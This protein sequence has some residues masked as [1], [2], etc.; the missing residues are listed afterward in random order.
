VGFGFN[1]LCHVPIVDRKCEV[2]SKSLLKNSTNLP[3]EELKK[4]FLSGVHAAKMTGWRDVVVV[5]S[6]YKHVV[7]H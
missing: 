1:G 3:P 7:N 4:Y 6:L 5:L 2:V